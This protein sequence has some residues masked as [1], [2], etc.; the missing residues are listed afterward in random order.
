MISFTAWGNSE[1]RSEPIS[2][3]AGRPILTGHGRDL[4]QKS[5][6]FR[7]Q[8]DEC[9]LIERAAL[10]KIRPVFNVEAKRTL[11]FLSKFFHSAVCL[12]MIAQV[13]EHLARSKD[14]EVHESRRGCAFAAS[15]MVRVCICVSGTMIA[16]R[17]VACRM[18]G[19]V[20]YA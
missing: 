18:E 4:D 12:S 13:K 2:V 9:G 5:Y 7:S 19:A 20:V 8:L 1:C 14:S 10:G 11:E 17:S 15:L 6:R 3:V 16:G